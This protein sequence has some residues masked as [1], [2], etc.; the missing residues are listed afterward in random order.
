MGLHEALPRAC[1]PDAPWKT[2]GIAVKYA[3]MS[4]GAIHVLE[5]M[6]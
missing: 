4:A 5:K 1:D 3:R 2:V 6:E